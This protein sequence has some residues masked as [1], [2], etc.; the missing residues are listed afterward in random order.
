MKALTLWQP[1]ATLVIEGVKPFEFRRWP[2]PNWIWDHRIGI[3]AGARP[4]RRKEIDQ[5][6]ADLVLEEGWGTALAVEP[7]LAILRKVRADLESIPLSSMLGTAVIGKPVP[8]AEAVVAAYGENF[9]GDSDRIDHQVFGW[10][11]RDIKRFEVPVPAK[12]LQGFWEWD[13]VAP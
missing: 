4:V 7:A 12:G 1:W 8:A 3:H 5:L 6:I 2:A 10:P 11:I 13:E 9:K